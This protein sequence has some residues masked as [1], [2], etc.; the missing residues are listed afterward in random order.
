MHNG[1]TYC[2]H[3]E[4]RASSRL[5]SRDAGRHLLAYAHWLAK[6]GYWPRRSFLAPKRKWF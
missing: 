3:L 2:Y 6:W 1:S 5:F 4:Q